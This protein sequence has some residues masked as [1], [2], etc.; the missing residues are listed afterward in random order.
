MFL[1]LR[2]NQHLPQYTP[3]RF[4]NIGGL[5]N[6]ILRS[7]WRFI[8]FYLYYTYFYRD[9]VICVGFSSQSYEIEVTFLFY[10]FRCVGVG[11]RCQFLIF[12]HDVYIMYG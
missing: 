9:A 4:Y 3:K 10:N 8:S 7:K 2:L 12:D 5:N 11:I 6:N 1:T